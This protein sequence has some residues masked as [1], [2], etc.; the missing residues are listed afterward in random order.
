L[1]LAKLEVSS[2]E[3]VANRTTPLAKSLALSIGTK[4]HIGGTCHLMMRTIAAAAPSANLGGETDIDKA[5]VD[6]WLSYIWSSVDLPIEMGSTSSLE[7]AA[8]E[9]FESHLAYR[10]YLV[11]HGVTVADIAL[12]VALSAA[13]RH[14]LWTPEEGTHLA[15]YYD[16]MTH[17]DFWTKAQRQASSSAAGTAAAAP[18]GPGVLMNGPAP[19]VINN[20]YRRQRIRIKELLANSGDNYVGKEVTVAGWTRTVRNANKGELLFVELNDGSCGSSL[21]CVLN[22]NE[23]A[24]FEECK[25]SGGTGSSFQFIGTLIPSQG[26]GQAVELQV[27]TGK[28][29]GAVYGA[30]PEGTEVGGMLY[31]LSKK[32]HTLEYM[33]EVAHLRPRARLHAAAMRIRHAMA[34]ATHNF[35][36]NH[37]FLYIHTPIITCADCEGAGE[38]FAV[39]TML[40]V[41]HHQPGI[42]LPV[43]E[44]PPVSMYDC[45]CGGDIP[46]TVIASNTIIA[47]SNHSSQKTPRRRSPK[48]SKSAWPR[49][50]RRLPRARTPTSLKNSRWWVQ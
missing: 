9:A 34:Y 43:Y 11:G 44:P 31:P 38:Q 5:N 17:Q 35:F 20:L 2:P 6:A 10:T 13:V 36:H 19:P 30:N 14:G 21:Q 37:G 18:T 50:Q 12:A 49:P 47:F 26:A 23:T 27:T 24:G 40:G 1:P 48:A 39:T 42:T 8:L 15:R 22:V 25:N 46:D 41:D 32:A 45:G 33:R 29:L 16:T 28:L 3:D 7:N 4:T